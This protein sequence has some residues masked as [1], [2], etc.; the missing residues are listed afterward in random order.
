MTFITSPLLMLTPVPVRSIAGTNGSCAI[1]V[2]AGRVGPFTGV[3]IVIEL[4]GDAIADPSVAEVAA[5]EAQSVRA[6]PLDREREAVG[7]REGAGRLHL[8]IEARL[9]GADIERVAS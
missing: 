7:Q 5:A 4:D 1:G 6:V 9:E 2:E 8:E 3:I